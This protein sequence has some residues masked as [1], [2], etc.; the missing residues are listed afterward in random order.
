MPLQSVS[1]HSSGSSCRRPRR[2]RSW[3]SSSDLALDEPAEAAQEDGLLAPRLGNALGGDLARL[4]VELRLERLEVTL[5]ELPVD[6]RQ[7]LRQQ[8]H[9]VA[10]AL[11]ARAA[12]RVEGDDGGR[13]AVRRLVVQDETLAVVE[14]PLEGDRVVGGF[15]RRSLFVGRHVRRPRPGFVSSPAHRARGF[16]SALALGFIRRA[17]RASD[18]HRM[19]FRR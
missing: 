5:D 8:L 18:H 16:S 3:R 13:R 14:G 2:Q 17:S 19:A 6:E 10:E 11:R 9:L 12:G 15:G 7:R 4:G 1:F